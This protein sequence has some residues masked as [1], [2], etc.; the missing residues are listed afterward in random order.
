[1]LSLTFQSR[2]FPTFSRH[3]PEG[4]VKEKREEEQEEEGERGGGGG[5]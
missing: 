1:M 5:C 2:F 4:Q 3:I